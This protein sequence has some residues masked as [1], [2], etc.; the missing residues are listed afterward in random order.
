VRRL[1]HAVSDQQWVLY[2]FLTRLA[3][4]WAWLLHRNV[5]YELRGPLFEF[6]RQGRP[7]I[8]ALWHQDVFP[9][10]LKLF[11]Y[12]PSYP[13]YFMV[14]HGR[15]GAIGTLLLN[16][17]DIECVAGSRSRRGVDAVRELTRRV[18]E[19]RRSVFLM[20]DG[21]RGPARQARWGAI[22]LARDTGL[23]IIAVRAWGD[24]LVMLR[25]TWMQ[26]VLP[27]PWGRAV[28][29]S[30]DP[31]VVPADAAEGE[32]L[33]RLRLALEERLER[34]VADADAWLA[35]RE[36]GGTLARC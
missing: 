36:R 30:A 23:P 6:I 10:M 12:T 22:H 13:S 32:A 16:R 18:R 29:L 31:L 21:S 2:P 9:L 14:S 33:D 25:R 1:R 3:R 7:C 8:V 15:I 26:L 35:A 28:L 34:L 17:W 27:K 11:E 5:R 19:E 20:A 4:I 24:N